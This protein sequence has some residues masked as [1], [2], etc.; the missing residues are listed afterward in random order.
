MM[1][2]LGRRIEST[3]P[4]QACQRERP[5][6]RLA[7]FLTVLALL[8]ALRV[9][10]AGVFRIDSDEPQ[11]LHVV[12]GVAGGLVQ[13]RDIFDNH[14]PLFQQLCAPLFR[15]LG[16]RTDI[17]VTMRLAMVPLYLGCIACVYGIAARLFSRECGAMAALFT[18]LYPRFFCTSLEF[19]PDNLWALA[20]LLLL[21]TLVCVRRPRLRAAMAGVLLGTAFSVSMK[22]TVMALDLTAAGTLVWLLRGRPS[23]SPS[24][25]LERAAFFAVGVAIVPGVLLA[26]F[27][28]AGAL[29]DLYYCLIQHNLVAA[30]ERAHYFQARG[31]ASLAALAGLIWWAR[32][33]LREALPLAARRAFILLAGGFYPVLLF[34]VWPL[35][36]REDFL[37]FMPLVGL[38]LAPALLAGLNWL[39]EREHAALAAAVFPLLVALLALLA[40]ADFR[41]LDPFSGRTRFHRE[42]LAHTLK[43]TD[44]GDCV[45]DTKGEMVYRNRPFYFALEEMTRWRLKR[46]LTADDIPERMIARGVCVAA[47]HS[48]RYPLRTDHFLRE[49]YLPV[50]FRLMVAGKM[51]EPAAGETPFSIA[52]PTRYAVVGEG[53]GGELW[54]DGKRYEQPV[55]LMPGVHMLRASAA[56][57]HVAV[58]WARALER[59]FSPFYHP[60]PE[61]EREALRARKENIL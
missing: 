14:S 54:L 36:T 19:R 35:V 2:S 17:V 52:I 11:H 33:M 6:V 12:W 23:F 47:S 15:V 48:E 4:S 25:L 43:L 5:G 42:F 58:V 21:A 53:T 30:T 45:M 61:E 8:A 3:L 20:W 39:R 44:P 29:H 40:V 26:R 57:G 31:A 55:V 59:G 51:L 60:S 9:Y 34:I 1:E 38:V 7:L 37:A 41:L 22:T 32:R 46:G 24:R 28:S 16:E 27:A 13:Y 10:C 50:A 18:A 49:N 56:A